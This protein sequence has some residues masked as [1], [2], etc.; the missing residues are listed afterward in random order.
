MDHGEPLGGL[1]RVEKGD[2]RRVSVPTAKERP[3]LADDQVRRQD[4]RAGRPQADGDTVV[5][6]T[7]E[8]ADW[9][10]ATNAAS[11]WADRRRCLTT[12]ARAGGIK[13]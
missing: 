13:R 1:D 11:R 3:G 12:T 2:G 4:R 5:G 9:L 8:A 6:I 7:A 10:A